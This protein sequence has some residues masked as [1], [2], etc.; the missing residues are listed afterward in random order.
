MS[1][2]FT[3]IGTPAAVAAKCRDAIESGYKCSEPEE[4][5][6]KNILEIAAMVAQ[7]MGQEDVAVRVEASGSMFTDSGKVKTQNLRLLVEP[8][9]GFV[10]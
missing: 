3:A 8:V 6:R 10:S 2:S 4:A 7:S 5:A 9:Y 1:W